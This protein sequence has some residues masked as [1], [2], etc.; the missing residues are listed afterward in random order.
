MSKAHND[1]N[2]ETLLHT[3]ANP[4]PGGHLSWPDFIADFRGV[5]RR[6][7]ANKPP[8]RPTPVCMESSLC[9]SGENPK[10]KYRLSIS[11]SPGLCHEEHDG[12]MS[13]S[14][15]AD[16]DVDAGVNVVKQI[17]TGVVGVLVDREIVAAVPAPIG[18]YR[19]VPRRY[20]KIETARQPEAM[21]IGI[22]AFD[23]IAVRRA[24]VFEPAMLERMIEVEAFVIRTI[25]AV[26]VVVVDVRRSI[27]VAGH[28]ALGFG[29]GVWVVSPWRW[30]RNAA[31]IGAGRI[32]PA[33]LTVF[34]TALSH[35]RE[36]HEHCQCNCKNEPSFHFLLL[37]QVEITPL[38]Q[39]V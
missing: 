35:N 26:S 28:M 38:A 13:R 25:V 27:H 18:T 6:S 12:R 36:G 29:L 39:L 15:V 14:H 20:F 5:D 1:S 24:K 9:Q 16:V 34:L 21:M 7:A 23:A 33:F 4:S 11:T 2:W 8:F 3:T 22:E 37:D 19:P 32:L 31:L 17:P 30:R 10:E